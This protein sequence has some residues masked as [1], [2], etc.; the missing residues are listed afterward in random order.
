MFGW[1][2]K[3]EA[4]IA[5]AKDNRRLMRERIDAVSNR[6]AKIER[7]M[8]S[9]LYNDYYVC[10]GIR[11]AGPPDLQKLER[12][13]SLPDSLDLEWKEET[14]KGYIKKEKEE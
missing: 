1:R 2:K 7:M 9:D 11:W 14:V 5:D 3:I 6:L 8:S 10:T 12:L 4:L 13:L